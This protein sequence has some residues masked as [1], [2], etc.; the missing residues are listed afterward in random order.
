MQA[1]PHIHIVTTNIQKNG[2]RISIHN[3]GKNQSTQ[4][5]KEIETIYN[6]AKAEDQSR[7]QSEEIK[8]LNVQ[9][10]TYGKSPTK[11]GIINVLD[12]VLPK[13][14]YAS[15][16]ELNAVL[17]IYNLTADRGKEEGIIFRKRGLVYRVL[18]ER[19]NKIGV[20]IKASSIYNKPTLAFLEGKFKENELLKQA[21][22]K[23]LKTSIDWIMV[24]PPKSLQAFKEGLLKEKINLVVRENDKG[25]IY[26]MTYIDY[27]TKCV[28]NGSDI[29]KE[30]SA[31]SI[32]EK[33]GITQTLPLQ[34]KIF[35]RKKISITERQ[36]F[37]L[38]LNTHQNNKQNLSNVLE[39]IIKPVEENTYLPYELRKQKIEKT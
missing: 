26:G 10:V 39:V 11:R 6:L 3:I 27:K 23:S 9:R 36:E 30:Y 2:K 15:L 21:H 13:Y 28:F 24:M 12:A 16:A 14:K 1:H 17:K 38:E 35:I 5:R 32:L 34:E 22:K 29:G 7:L 19:G 8:P 31:K 18:D 25:I 20:P 33:C 37:K 4:A